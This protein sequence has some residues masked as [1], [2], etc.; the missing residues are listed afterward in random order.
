MRESHE[1]LSSMVTDNDWS[2]FAER[3]SLLKYNRLIEFSPET[4]PT[5]IAHARNLMNTPVPL[6]DHMQVN[7]LLTLYNGLRSRLHVEYLIKNYLTSIGNV[8][9]LCA[10]LTLLQNP[11]K[12]LPENEQEELVTKARRQM[13]IKL[14]ARLLRQMRNL[15]LNELDR[16]YPGMFE[17]LQ[18][19][20][21][22][23]TPEVLEEADGNWFAKVFHDA[24]GKWGTKY[25]CAGYEVQDPEA[26]A[27]MIAWFAEEYGEEGRPRYIRQFDFSKSEENIHAFKKAIAVEWTPKS[28]ALEVWNSFVDESRAETRWMRQW[29]RHIIVEL[30]TM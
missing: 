15:I 30:S 19:L 24:L 29:N 4:K 11:G 16:T 9:H 28:D 1:W 25:L 10:G 18:H 22:F 23:I 3:P 12:K 8:R 5:L 6:L 21:E 13:A 27:R 26:K 14:S 2:S 20:D 17:G 7:G